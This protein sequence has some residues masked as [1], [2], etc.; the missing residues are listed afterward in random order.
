M[1]TLRTFYLLFIVLIV[2]LAR[3]LLS[4]IKL[5]IPNHETHVLAFEAL[6]QS[7]PKSYVA[8]WLQMVTAWEVDARNANIPNLYVAQRSRMSFHFCLTLMTFKLY[9]LP[10]RSFT[11]QD[12]D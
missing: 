4:R 8:Q 12:P 9:Y 6:T 7:L 2:S 1:C 11:K 10:P 5:A 3:T